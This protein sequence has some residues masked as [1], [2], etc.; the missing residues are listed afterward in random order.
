MQNVSDQLAA[1]WLGD[2][3]TQL[4]LPDRQVPVRVNGQL[5]VGCYT[6]QAARDCYVGE[7]LDVLT[8]RGDRIAEIT[9][10]LTSTLHERFGHEGTPYVTAEIFAAFGLPET[11][12]AGR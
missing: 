6:W 4:R 12:P 11:L 2:V 3:S 8:L 7:V 10:F 1:S 9:A 5:A